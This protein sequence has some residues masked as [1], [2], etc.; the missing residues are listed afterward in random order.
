MMTFWNSDVLIGWFKI[1]TPRYLKKKLKLLEHLKTLKTFFY[2]NVYILR[3]RL[4][5]SA[6]LVA[7][8]G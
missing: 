6:K 2:L 3:Y 4:F 8:V 7:T 1:L 5:I